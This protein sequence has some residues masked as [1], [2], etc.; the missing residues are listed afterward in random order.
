VGGK[1]IP[2]EFTLHD[3]DEHRVDVDLTT[4]MKVEG[5][6]PIKTEMTMQGGAPVKTESALT[7]TKP[8]EM[9]TTLKGAEPIKTEVGLDI[10]PLRAELDI[11]PLTLDLCVNV[12]LNSLPP[13]RICRQNSTHFGFTLFGVEVV[14][15]NYATDNRLQIEPLT[16]PPK[17]AWGGT[18][19]IAAH[20]APRTPARARAENADGGLRIKLEE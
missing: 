11:K 1:G 3:P 17:V 16:P 5:G 19:A 15:F 13:T 4:D 10:K 8:V 14:G 7:L 20:S 12:G 9:V 18:E 6:A 2:D